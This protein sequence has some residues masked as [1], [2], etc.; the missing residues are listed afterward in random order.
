MEFDLIKNLDGQ[1]GLKLRFLRHTSKWVH[2]IFKM[3]SLDFQNG[4]MR[5]S[6]WVHEIFKM[7]S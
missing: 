3:G 7:G 4:F 6:K 5:F 2:E 1:I